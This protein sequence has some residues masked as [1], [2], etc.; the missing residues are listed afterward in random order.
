MGTKKI[1]SLVFWVRDPILK[2]FFPSPAPASEVPTKSAVV[3]LRRCT[4]GSQLSVVSTEVWEEFFFP[5]FFNSISLASFLFP[6]P[7]HQSTVVAVIAM[8]RCRSSLLSRFLCFGFTTLPLS[9]IRD[10][11]NIQTRSYPTRPEFDG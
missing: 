1:F 2:V 8:P 10:G 3:S 6:F 7:H 11:N 4:S 9:I 5:F